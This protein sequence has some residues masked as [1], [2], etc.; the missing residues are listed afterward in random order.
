MEFAIQ[1][2]RFV[3]LALAIPFLSAIWSY[4][5]AA[6]IQKSQGQP[7]KSKSWH[8][9][10]AVYKLLSVLGFAVPILFLRHDITKWQWSLFQLGVYLLLVMAA[11]W[12]AFDVQLNRRRNLPTY[13]LGQSSYSDL[14]LLYV[15]RKT[16][17]PDAQVVA[18]CKIPFLVVT[19]ILFIISMQLCP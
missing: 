16:G 8:R 18:F 14:V 5:D 9:Q 11:W 7:N 1:V 6:D 2:A 4:I 10:R 17:L 15:Q 13:R 19:L 3:F 12:L